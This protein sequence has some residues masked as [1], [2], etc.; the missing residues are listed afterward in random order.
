MQELYVK[1]M[2]VVKGE[3]DNN[4]VAQINNMNKTDIITK[5]T[6]LYNTHKTIIVIDPETREL[7]K[8]C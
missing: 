4:F 7:T 1:C 6:N 3:L 5:L 8:L 2:S